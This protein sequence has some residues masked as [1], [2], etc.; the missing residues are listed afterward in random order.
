[1][2]TLKD[3]NLKKMEEY[4][5]TGKKFSSKEEEYDYVFKR[6]LKHL[7]INLK[8][9]LNISYNSLLEALGNDTKAK[10]EPLAETIMNIA[11]YGKYALLMEDKVQIANFLRTEAFKK[12]NWTLIK[13]EDP[14]E[15]E[16]PFFKFIFYN[17]AVDEGDNL[18]GYVFVNQAGNVRYTVIQATE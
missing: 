9:K 3:L 8:K 10:A 13:M 1:M 16:E 11:P 5:K 4:A 7:K 6:F 15:N 18:M 2:K 14:K 17:K 12:N